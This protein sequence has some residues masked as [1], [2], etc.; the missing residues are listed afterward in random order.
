LETVTLVLVLLVALPASS[1]LLRMSR[2]PLPLPLAQIAIGAAIGSLT[3][4]RVNLE[5][6]IFFLLFL[7][8]LLFVD[9]WRIPKQGLFRDAGTILELAL[10]LVVFTV[11]G[12]AFF[13]HW[14]IP[15]MPLAV[16]F[17]LAAVLSP[18]DPVAVSSIAARAPIPKRM[19]HILE[20]ESL[21]NDASGL[22]CLRFAKAAALTG[23]FA[24]PAAFLTFLQLALG[25][26]AVGV[27]V[28][29]GIVAAK[30]WVARRYGEEPGVQILISLLMPFAAYLAAEQLHCSGILAAVAAGITMSYAELSGQA[31]AITR[32]RRNAVWETLQ[33][34]ANG[35][36]FIVLGEQ[37]PAIFSRAAS[38][39]MES[40]HHQPWWLA[41]HVVA[42]TL[43]L[44][45][46]RLLWVW[47][48]L[49]L[50]LF[51]AARNGTARPRPSWRLLAAGTVAGVRGAITLAGILTL[52]LSMPDGAAFPSR[53]LAIFIAAGVIVLSLVIASLAL[54]P[55]LSGY[56]L[57]PEP[58][59][60]EQ[61]DR[62]RRAAGDAAIR[63]IER[64]QHEMSEGRADADIYAT[65]AARAM[66]LYR[67][68]SGDRVATD[69]QAQ[70]SRQ[71]DKIA[72]TLRLAG[73][74]AEREEIFRLA[75]RIVRELDLMEARYS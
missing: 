40:G 45:V 29:W 26:I 66:D 68:R 38:T 22:V 1:F 52:P 3:H 44:G 63:T 33:Y 24:L 8:P 69:Q 17:A 18:T 35:V 46:L 64:V 53:D 25:G 59:Q 9:G 13:L 11:V 7:P 14:L 49:Q 6:E 56:D 32:V 55:L 34:T 16:C 43:A 39:V 67:L 10:G 12:I 51:R 4:L 70:L 71:V 36:V 15:T 72:V 41:I 2:L 57:L 74:R 37:L 48:S 47:A 20:G 23:T 75:R 65:A 42:V 5:P 30:N 50:T 58:S 60:A 19:M 21:L 27:F 73:L 62:A 61:E 54:P 28:T 31:T